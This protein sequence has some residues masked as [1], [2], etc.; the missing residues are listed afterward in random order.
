MSRSVLLIT[1]A[2]GWLGNTLLEILSESKVSKD[3]DV[4]IIFSL[5]QKEFK[6]LKLTRDKFSKNKIILK[7]IYGEITDKS[8][9]LKLNKFLNNDDKLSIIYALSIIHAKS[10]KE[11]KLINCY[12]L[13]RF[14]ENIK[15]KNLQKFVYISSNSPF[16]FNNSKNKFNELSKY[17]PIGNYGKTKMIAE[18]FL[19]NNLPKNKLKII[20]S[21]WFH[22]PNMPERQKL[23]LRKVAIGSFP[24]IYPGNNKRS[25]INTIDLSK[26]ILNLLKYK[27][28]HTIYCVCEPK[29]IKMYDLIS[30]I[31]KTA[32]DLEIEKVTNK[33]ILFLPPLTSN[34]FIVFDRLVQKLGLY[35]KIIHVM[36][37]L[38]MNIEMDSSRYRNE[39]PDHKFISINKS[40]N[41]ELKEAIRKH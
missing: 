19:K 15:N 2:G 9:Y 33:N 6:K 26:A 20:R 27:S 24:I 30:L 10:A 12:G 7:S 16:G 37:E 22:G 29:S 35:S 25:I 3:Y 1:G 38:G 32:K 5:F 11:F 40:I 23:F 4:I 8:I 34:I 41:H 36:S 14:V 13:E 31:Q 28:D 21:P 18:K 17:S 39:F